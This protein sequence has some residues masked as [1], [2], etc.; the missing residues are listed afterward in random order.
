MS[1]AI[2]Q[3][4]VKE[5]PII[6]SGPMVRAILEGRKTQTR[7]VVKPL[8]AWFNRVCTCSGN[9]DRVTG[10][11]LRH[12]CLS[13]LTAEFFHFCPYGVPQERLWVRETFVLEQSVDGNKPP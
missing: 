9:I 4:K 6:F 12:D 11:T 13:D 7:R 5:R 10:Q 2:A 3:T 1:A 8:P